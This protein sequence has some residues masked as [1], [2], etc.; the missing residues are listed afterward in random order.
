MAFRVGFIVA[1]L[2]VWVRVGVRVAR[3]VVVWVGVGVRVCVSVSG[4]TFP[5]FV[6]SCVPLP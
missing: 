4:G 3:F 2:V 6:I 5:I 1:R